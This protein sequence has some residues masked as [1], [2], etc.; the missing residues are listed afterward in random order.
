MCLNCIANAL[1]GGVIAVAKGILSGIYWGMK[2]FP[3]RDKV[4]FL[5]RQSNTPSVDFQWLQAALLAEEPGLEIVQI[6]KRLDR[7]FVSALRFAW[8]SLR[9][10]YHLATAK[11]C[12]LDTYWPVVSIL[13]HKDSLA[14]IQMWHAIGKIKQSGY[15]TLDRKYGRG[16]DIAETM[17]MHKGYDVVIA[18]NPS[19]NDYYC[20]SFG[21][22]E[23]Q[24]LNVGLPRIDYLLENRQRSR[25]LALS[26]YPEL[27]GKTVVL[28]APTFR[29][30]TAADYSRLVQQ[31]PADRFALIVKPH[32]NQKLRDARYLRP[33]RYSELTTMQALDACDIVI[34]DFSA[35]SFEAAALRKPIYFYLFD[36]QEY[37]REN[38]VNIDPHREMPGSVYEDLDALIDAVVQG[39]YN[40]QEL[41]RFCERYLPEKLGQSTERLVR[42]I[43]DCMKVGKH[44]GIRQNL[45]REDEA[46]VSVA[47]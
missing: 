21:V 38:G 2:H 11:V 36:Y 1:A 19:M 43:V 37:I 10:M 40:A 24:L 30:G 45:H 20:A 7:S 6:T 44:E 33:W 32:P 25:E 28:Y 26:L 27:Q 5:S 41:D 42:L 34:T 14:V 18:G 39:A 47:G 31:F 8:H 46:G 13:R 3:S 35:I 9:S 23:E 16:S 12:V 17:N 29:K 4:V 15:Q 22:E